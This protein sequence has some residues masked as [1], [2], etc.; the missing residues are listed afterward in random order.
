MRSCPDSPTGPFSRSPIS[1]RLHGSPD[2]LPTTYKTTHRASSTVCFA[3]RIRNIGRTHG[4]KD[5]VEAAKLLAS[6][7]EFHFLLI[8]WG[9]RKQWAIEQKQAHK[10]ENLT[11]LDPLEQNDLCDGLNACD[12]S[13][14]AFSRGMSGI[15]V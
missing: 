14:I 1:H 4:I 7:P 10:L 6:D 15:S 5:I 8:G 13:L 3:I 2:T 11:I 9:A 12:V